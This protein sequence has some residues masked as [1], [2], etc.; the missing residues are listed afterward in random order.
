MTSSILT[1]PLGTGIVGT[2]IKFGRAPAALAGAAVTVD[3]DAERA[4]A[5]VPRDRRD[6]HACTDITGFGLV[7]HATEMASQRRPL[8]LC[9]AHCRIF[10]GVR[11]MAARTGRAAWPRTRSTS[12]PERWIDARPSIL[13]SSDI[14]FDP[15][16]S[17][18]LLVSR[19]PPPPP[20]R[21]RRARQPPG[22]ARALSVC[23]Q[24]R[25]A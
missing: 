22:T 11:A 15:Q 9:R 18:G 25:A 7:G 6:V 8:E 3:D 13:R 1:K 24:G 14:A 5:Q 19:S 2:A 23:R 20:M 17:G 10:D 21:V 12:G 16:T 4:R